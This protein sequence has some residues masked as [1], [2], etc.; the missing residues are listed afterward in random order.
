MADIYILGI[1]SSCDD[2]SAAVLKNGVILSNVTA[3]QEVHRA[4]GG[5]VPELAS[6]AHQQNVVPV[7]DQALK[8]AGI[9]KEQLSAI[10]FT[11]GPGLMGSLL[12]GVNFAKGFARSL[13]IPL[14][15][16]NHLQ[17]HVMAHFIKENEAD[18]HMP[19]FPFICLL[20]S[21]GNSQIV[22]VNA[23][24]DM[25][26]L[27]Q[28]IDDAAGEAIDKCAKVLEWGYPGGPVI[29]KYARQGNPHAFRFSEPHIEGFDYS[30]SGFKT[31]FLYSLR[32]WIADDPKFIEKNKFDLA[33]SIEFTIVDILM[34]K[35]RL[36][37]KE[38]GITHVAVAGGVSAN[39]GLR[40]AFKEHA[41]KYGWTIYIP[42]FSY[43]T[44]NAAMI[45]CVGT[46]KYLDED[47]ATINLPAFS[48][49]TFK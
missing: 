47:F 12:V 14:I 32:K 27:G 38:T 24:N 28:T 21:G 5:V 40:N 43:T 45:A 44:D 11:R 31:S 10:A 36:A 9:T 7:V 33:A 8:K 42:K 37:V 15:D 22:K 35:L 49:V 17:G 39:N 20:V 34:K 1:E 6:R 13:E 3:S 41:E 26:V 19:P 16:V 30:F 46:F 18:D 2:T 23:Y 25:E 29:D 48:K 4:Y